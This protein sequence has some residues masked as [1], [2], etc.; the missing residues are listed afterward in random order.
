MHERERAAAAVEPVLE[1]AA[2]A[3]AGQRVELGEVAH[4]LERAGGLDRADGVVGEGAQRAQL[5]DPRQQQ[6]DRARRPTGS[7]AARRSGRA[8]APSASG[9]STRAGRWPLLREA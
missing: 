1:A 8:A 5:V 4:L 2:V 9:G 7:P 3:Q 6:V